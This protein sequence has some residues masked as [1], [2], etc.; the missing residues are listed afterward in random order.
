MI[1]ASEGTLC[2]TTLRV[3]SFVF[4]LPYPHQQQQRHKKEDASKLE[5]KAK[6]S[7]SLF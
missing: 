5:E 2:N 6:G 4:C 1:A 7:E 3:P